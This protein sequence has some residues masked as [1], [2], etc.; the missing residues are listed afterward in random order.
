MHAVDG[1]S[2]TVAAGTI[3]ALIGPN[4]SGKTTT[5][6]LVGGSVRA[7]SGTV[8]FDGQRIDRLPAWSRAHRGLG[9][10][11]QTTRLFY[12]MTVLENVV[13]PLRGFSWRGLNGLAVTGPEAARA[14][15]LLDLVGMRRWRE[16]KAVALSYGQ[17]KLVELA[18]ILMLEPTL[19]LLDEP[20]G[21]ITPRL[22]DR[23]GELIVELNRGGTTFLVVEHNMPFVLDL[24]DS[25]LVLARG[26]C[27]RSGPPDEVRRDPLVLDVYLGQTEPV[28]EG[29]RS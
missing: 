2:F 11:F 21:G 8:W 5:F 23:M 14:D 16:Q 18:Q 6:D 27:I 25:V 3:T 7:D 20:A 1:C 12:D 26:R 28:G 17:R 9:R 15:E 24:A 4:G 13:A 29:T 19:I 10:T 22:V